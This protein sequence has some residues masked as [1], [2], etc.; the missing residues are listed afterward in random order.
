MAIVVSLS[1]TAVSKGLHAGKILKSVASVLDGN[2][3]G[4]DKFAEG[5]GKNIDK[6]DDA[7]KM[8]KELIN[9]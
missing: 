2:G 3:G 9:G 8:S 1:D 6:I 4:R 7:I 5:R